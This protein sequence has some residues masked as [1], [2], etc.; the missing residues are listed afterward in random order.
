MNT[1][2]CQ[3]FVHGPEYVVPFVFTV[4]FLNDAVYTRD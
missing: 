3:P 1:F 4:F 2:A